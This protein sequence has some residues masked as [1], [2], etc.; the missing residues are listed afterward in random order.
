MKGEIYNYIL[1]SKIGTGSTSNK[2]FFVDW[3][4][5]PESRYKMTFTCSCQSFTID[6]TTEQPSVFIN[7]L[8]ISNNILCPS[9]TSSGGL[10]SGFIGTLSTV[11]ND[12]GTDN[13]QLTT[14][15]ANPPSFLRSK[16]REY[17]ITV[18]IHKNTAVLNANY[19]V[20]D[21]YTMILSFEQLD[22]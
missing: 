13:Q 4:R 12:S 22:D 9:P 19:E 20:M 17:T 2:S 18:R 8:G 10:N 16:P 7:E 5:M 15:H 21:N 6:D 11:I 1:Y 14:I 3:G